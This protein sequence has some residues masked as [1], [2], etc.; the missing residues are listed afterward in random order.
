MVYGWGS[1]L[2]NHFKI[3]NI[4]I[5]NKGGR[6]TLEPLVIL[7]ISSLLRIYMIYGWGS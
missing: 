6:M 2:D 7:F 5:Y 3:F 1:H 4:Q